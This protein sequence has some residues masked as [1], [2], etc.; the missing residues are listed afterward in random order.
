M[1]SCL[2]KIKKKINKFLSLCTKVTN[3]LGITLLFRSRT[4]N[5]DLLVQDLKKR[6][7]SEGL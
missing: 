1:L 6:D 7:E 4:L 3:K 5:V 2:E